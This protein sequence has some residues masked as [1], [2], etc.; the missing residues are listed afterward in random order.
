MK[1]KAGTK[2][3]C[4]N[5]DTHEGTEPWASKDGCIVDNIYTT[6][7]QDFEDDWVRL[8]DSPKSSYAIPLKNFEVV[9]MKFKVGDIV[10]VVH[11]GSGFGDDGEC[12]GGNS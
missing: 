6:Q 3:K 5:L 10:K 11:L 8:V 2:V 1:L 12:L 9:T 7:E 4:I